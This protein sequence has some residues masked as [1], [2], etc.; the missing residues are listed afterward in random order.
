[1]F[2]VFHSFSQVCELVICVCV[3]VSSLSHRLSVPGGAGE[4]SSSSAGLRSSGRKG[5][6]G[7]T[8]PR[9]D[10]EPY[11]RTGVW[12]IKGV[13]FAVCSGEL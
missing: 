2:Q 7:L 10:S 5:T 1:M 3:V 8:P 12:K 6:R 13:V 11:K 9:V 4:V